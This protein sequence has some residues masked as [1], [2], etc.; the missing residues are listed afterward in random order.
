MVDLRRVFTWLAAT[1]LLAACAGKAPAPVVAEPSV[2]ALV[3]EAAQA[4]RDGR[5]DAA[6][7]RYEAALERAPGRLDAMEGRALALLA[8]GR[9]D[10]ARSGFEAVIAQAPTRWRALDGMGRLADR[11][12]DHATAQQW[13]E[14]ALSA[15]GADAVV[16]NNY[17]WSRVLARDY[18]RAEK[19]LAQ[20][21]QRSPG[22]A[23]VAT[24]LAVAI[25]W[26]GDYARAVATA[27]TVVPEYVAS[28]DVGY[29]AMLRGDYVQAIRYFETAIDL[30]PNWYA[31]AAANLERARR[32]ATAGR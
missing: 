32:E 9:V 13:Y 27:M 3:A 14:R 22:S 20:A 23:Q 21:L 24:N 25:A 6:L 1:L 15:P 5:H 28:N 8:A 29:I 31:R 18:A 26:Q 7:P 19:L 17:G 30:S 12:G 2:D 16:W 11:T 10:E 4:L